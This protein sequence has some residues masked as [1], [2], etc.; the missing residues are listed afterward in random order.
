MLPPMLD[1][2]EM[3]ALRPRSTLYLDPLAV[4]SRCVSVYRAL[5]VMFA[6]S[7]VRQTV[8]LILSAL[9]TLGSPVGTNRL[10]RYIEHGG[11]GAVVRPWVW[12]ALIALAP[13]VQCGAEQ[14]SSYYKSRTTAQIDAVI[15]A[16]L[17]QHALRVRILNTPDEDQASSP[18]LPVPFT[19]AVT[20]ATV[21]APS[22]TSS[23]GQTPDAATVHSRAE[24]SSSTIT[25]VASV[26]NDGKTGN[27]VAPKTQVVDD[28]RGKKDRKNQDIVGRLNVLVTSDM[29]NIAIG[30]DWIRVLLNTSLQAVL[31]SWFVLI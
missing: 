30:T 19:T 29:N 16:T 25:A 4:S 26:N 20:T 15:T 8:L 13:L 1:T 12:I 24:S 3:H 17:H 28:K 23:N 7:W 9:A 5:L 14:L 31:G 11:E 2:D 27:K 18:S 6:G 10:L 21:T 22:A